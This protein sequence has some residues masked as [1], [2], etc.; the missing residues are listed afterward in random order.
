MCTHHPKSSFLLLPYIHSLVLNH[1]SYLHFSPWLWNQVSIAIYQ[2]ACNNTFSY[3]RT[4]SKV[5]CL[6]DLCLLQ[7]GK[8]KIDGESVR[9]R[10]VIYN[11]KLNLIRKVYFSLTWEKPGY[12]QSRA[13]MEAP[14]SPGTTYF[15]VDFSTIAY[16]MLGYDLWSSFIPTGIKCPY[17]QKPSMD[18][19]QM[20]SRF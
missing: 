3:W 12:K 18:A 20:L 15:I 5:E 11:R 9:I 6:L 1:T 19:V 17:Y 7:K 8:W 13:E 16:G 2:Q 14:Q 4:K 10:V